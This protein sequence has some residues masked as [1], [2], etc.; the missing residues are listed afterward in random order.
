MMWRLYAAL[1]SGVIV[2]SFVVAVVAVVGDFFL[3]VCDLCVTEND[4][5]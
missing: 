3:R 5:R 2:V 1:V 4:G